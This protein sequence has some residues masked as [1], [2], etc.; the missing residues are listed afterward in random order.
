MLD[1]RK[2]T[3]EELDSCL[4]DHEHLEEVKKFLTEAIESGAEVYFDRNRCFSILAR[5][6]EM[7]YERRN[8]SK[9]IGIFMS[10]H[11]PRY[12]ND[13][14]VYAWI[15][16]ED[17]FGIRDGFNAGEYSSTD[18][19][20]TVLGKAVIKSGTCDFCQA[21]VGLKNLIHV[22]FANKACKKCYRDAKKELEYPDWTS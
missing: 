18:G 11:G 16:V 20:K 21:N 9:V 12:S 2:I 1:E 19:Y 3:I 7:E 10:I 5:V 4:E 6:L 17:S 8:K 13:D 15:A 22:G 14:K